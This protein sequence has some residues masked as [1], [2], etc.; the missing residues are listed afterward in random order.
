MKF[1]KDL[2]VRLSPLIEAASGAPLVEPFVETSE[3]PGRRL[4]LR[5]SY[6]TFTFD[7]AQRLVLKDEEVIFSFSAVQSI[8]LAAFPGGRGAKSWSI[9]LYRGLID[10]TTVARTYDDGEASVVGAKL[11]RAI[12]CRVVSLAGRK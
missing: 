11:A 12:G 3:Q 7:R 2:M 1:S 10:R 8:A 4:V 6:G 5:S 9:S